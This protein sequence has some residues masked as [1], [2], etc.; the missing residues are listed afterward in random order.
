MTVAEAIICKSNGRSCMACMLL[1]LPSF[2]F[3]APRRLNA[4]VLRCRCDPEHQKVI[5]LLCKTTLEFHGFGVEEMQS[6]VC[7]THLVPTEEGCWAVIHGIRLML[8]T[9]RTLLSLCSLLCTFSNPCTSQNSLDLRAEFVW[10]WCR[11]ASTL[12]L[13]VTWADSPCAPHL[14]FGE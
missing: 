14:R 13:V 7:D 10:Q 1:A 5:T 11:I 12:L 8:S 6:K 3:S 4:P 2:L 9:E